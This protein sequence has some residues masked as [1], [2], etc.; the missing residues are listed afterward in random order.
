MIGDL[1]DDRWAWLQRD[2]ESLS[3]LFSATQVPA[4]LS[5]FA[6]QDAGR[7][8][9]LIAA[10]AAMA[11]ALHLPPQEMIPVLQQ[12]VQAVGIHV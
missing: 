2:M 1:V 6:R 12:V 9:S 4:E 11:M 7:S 8:R 10:A 5:A 3:I